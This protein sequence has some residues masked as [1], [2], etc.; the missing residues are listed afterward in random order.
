MLSVMMPTGGG[1]WKTVIQGTGFFVAADGTAITASHVVAWAQRDPGAH[2][3]VAMVG[4]DLYAAEIVCASH[5]PYD[6]TKSHL[7]EVPLGRDIAE[8]RLTTSA[9]PFRRLFYKTPSG[10]EV[11]LA[12]AHRGPLGPF[13]FLAI[14]IG[15][16]LNQAV[17]VI[18]FGHISPIPGEWTATGQV[19]R[20]RQAGDGTPVFD[21]AFEGRP[22]P[23]NSG[24]PVLNARNQVVGVW[25]WQFSASSNSGT[26]QGAEVLRRPCRS[27]RSPTP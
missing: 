2:R 9:P 10:E 25:T 26:A 8:V 12:T 19:A 20:I 1:Y 15:P 16:A 4:R 14:G 11:T 5:L 7:S 6:P 22:Q 21:V 18:G 17:R 24:S 27:R 23:G 13:P 3:L